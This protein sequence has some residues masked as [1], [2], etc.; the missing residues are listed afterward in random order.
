[1]H[2]LNNMA[3]VYDA[4]GQPVRALEL[5]EQALPLW[6]EGGDRAGEATTLNNIALLL[7]PDRNRQQDAINAMQQAIAVLDETGLP[8][9]AA[10]RTREEL[11]QSLNMM[12]QSSAPR[13][14]N[15]TET[16]PA[17]QIQVIV[18]ST[19]AVMTTIQE[20]HAEWHKRITSALQD[21][22]ERGADWQIEVDFYAAVLALLD[23]QTPSVPDDHPYAVALA[24]IQSCIAAGGGQEGGAEEGGEAPPAEMS[25]RLCG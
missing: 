5:Y 18:D 4:T 7:Y 20:R 3:M 17:A 16:M 11:Q 8:Q 15:Q 21:A 13:Q 25:P 10:G 6:R 22:Q 1:M 2:A 19:V 24:Q 23:G 9:D 12:R 14:A